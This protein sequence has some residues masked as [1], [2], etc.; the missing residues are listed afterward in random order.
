[1]SGA[2]ITCLVLYAVLLGLVFTQGGTTA[3]TAAFWVLI[4]LG[5]AH[6]VEMIVFFP[7]AKRAGGSLPGHLFQI[8]LFGVFHKKEL[9]TALTQS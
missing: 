2:K 5:V 4:A 6:M 8:F 3:G 1:M 7:L 9:D